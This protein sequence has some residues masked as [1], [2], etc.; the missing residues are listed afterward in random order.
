MNEPLYNKYRPQVFQD[1]ESEP[2]LKRMLAMRIQDG[3]SHAFMFS[4]EAGLGK[5]T[6]ARIVANLLK[7]TSFIEIDAGQFT[8][9]DNIRDMLEEVTLQG[10]GGGKTCVIIDECHGLSG[11]AA[12]ALLKTVEEPPEHLYWMFNTTNLG[13]VPRTLRSRCIQL[14]LKPYARDEIRRILLRIAHQEGI[15]LDDELLSVIIDYAHGVPRT[16][17]NALNICREAETV[18]QV[19]H[20]LEST[21]DIGEI[22]DIGN[23]LMRRRSEEQ[24]P[25]VLSILLRHRDVPVETMRLQLVRQF[26]A[27]VLKSPGNYV[28]ARRAM[29]LLYAFGTPYPSN[30]GLAPIL[31][32]VSNLL[33]FNPGES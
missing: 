15:S 4:G 21:T 5:T 28:V 18:E 20:L 9:I 7:C 13:K 26:T 22:A 11:K 2:H 14:V 8:G 31:R 1:F 29:E 17:I 12:D 32:S 25:V 6:L 3:S 24:W 23:I 33:L 27:V 19:R 30:E 16:A 10:F